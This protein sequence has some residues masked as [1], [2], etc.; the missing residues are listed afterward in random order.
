MNFDTACKHLI[1]HEGG[2]VNNPADPGGDTQRAVGVADDGVAGAITPAAVGAA[3]VTGV[4]AR[5]NARRLDFYARLSAWP[6]F[7]KGW[8]RR[9][10]G[11]L[12]CATGGV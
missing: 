2:Y 5:F 1:G 3:P 11:N 8:A 4:L 12:N 9:S 7:G 6:A 10:V